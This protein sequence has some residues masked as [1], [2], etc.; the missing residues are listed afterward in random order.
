MPSTRIET[1]RGWLGERRRDFVEAV[2]RALVR[3]ILIPEADRSIR[4]FE[5]DEDAIIT[6]P[7]AGPRYTVV[8]ITLFTGRSMEAKRRLYAALVEELAPFGLEARDIRTILVEV[9]RENWGLRGLPASEIEL[10][11]KVDV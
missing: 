4:L 7:H 11:F 6:P 5:V 2:Q 8:E 3:G 1:P 10:S 9:D